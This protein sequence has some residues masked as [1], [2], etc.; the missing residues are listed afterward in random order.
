MISVCVCVCVIAFVFNS[1]VIIRINISIKYITETFKTHK[2]IIRHVL[3][4]LDQYQTHT[5]MYERIWIKNKIN[6]SQISL[7]V[8][9]QEVKNDDQRE[10]V[11]TKVSI[12][13]I[14]YLRKLFNTAH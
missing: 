2:I 13:G 12:I 11:I 4:S 7:F 8:I 9:H 3:K 6:Y 10:I 5:Y 14:L 1:I